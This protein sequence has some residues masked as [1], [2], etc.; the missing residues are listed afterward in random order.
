M[1][2]MDGHGG[3]DRWTTLLVDLRF[4]SSPS[5]LSLSISFYSS[6]SS[7]ASMG[8][9]VSI[10][11]LEI[12]SFKAHNIKVKVNHFQVTRS[13]DHIRL[14][15][16][17]LRENQTKHKCEERMMHEIGKIKQNHHL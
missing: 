8:S 2:W 15:M 1:M 9:S 6:C 11:L 7:S 17:C 4:S 3:D 12:A 16:T 10:S 5:A 13:Y 14:D